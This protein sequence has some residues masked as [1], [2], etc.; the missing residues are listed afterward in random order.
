MKHG[1]RAIL[2]LLFATGL[3]LVACGGSRASE[4]LDQ[5]TVKRASM[6]EVQGITDHASARAI[7]LSTGFDPNTDIGWPAG[8]GAVEVGPAVSNPSGGGF[9][10]D[11]TARSPAPDGQGTCVLTVVV[12]TNQAG[13]V[14]G[15]DA[16]ANLTC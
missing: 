11:Y 4:A 13:E 8:I 16:R 9:V 6:G 12:P 7:S 15:G 2:G 10:R 5:L 1:W 3:T 14:V